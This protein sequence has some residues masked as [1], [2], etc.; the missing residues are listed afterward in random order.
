MLFWIFFQ[1]TFSIVILLFC[2]LIPTQGLNANQIILKYILGPAT[3]CGSLL[4][5]VGICAAKEREANKVR[6]A[7]KPFLRYEGVTTFQIM[8]AGLTYDS[9]ARG[10][11]SMATLNTTGDFEQMYFED[12]V[13]TYV[14]Q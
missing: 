11:H 5:S 3:A 2:V 7:L 13:S 4:A 14:N 10:I 6:V 1:S 12:F 8:E 9:V